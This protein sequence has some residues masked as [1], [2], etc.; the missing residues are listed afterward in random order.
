[1]KNQILSVGIDIGTTTTQVIFSQITVESTATSTIPEVKITDKEIIYKSEIYFTPLLSNCK[2]NLE[3]LKKIIKAEY[4]KAQV[5]KQEISVGAIIITGETARKENAREVLKAL[6]DFAGDFVVA[7]AG[8]DLESILAGYGAGAAEVSKKFTDYVVNFD[9]GG[10]TTNAAVF[11]DG[12]VVDSFA[13][14]IGG[15]LIKIDNQGVIQYISNKIDPL[16]RYLN[17]QLAVGGQ[18]NLTELKMLTDAFAA[19][20]LQM[21]GKQKLPEELERL[22]IL[23]THK[24]I[25]A[26]LFMFSGGVAEF[27]Y[28]DAEIRSL[29][30]VSRFGDIGP[31]LG[32][33]IRKM[34]AQYRHRLL[35]PKE[36]IRATVIGAGSYSVKISGSTIVFDNALL[37]L[38]NVPIIKLTTLENMQYVIEKKVRLYEDIPVAIAFSGPKSPSYIQ[39]KEMAKAI[40]HGLSENHHP[41]IVIV[42]HDFAK[43]LGQI[44]EHIICKQKPVICIDRIKVDNGDYVDIGK[45]I[46]DIVPVVV[47]TLIFKT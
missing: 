47:K 28:S 14:N 10:G 30:D 46:T 15:R 35:E 41:M 24:G 4:E 21:N 12:E 23:H 18:A 6:A 45:S 13:L 16:L 32:D 39:V 27:I 7:T 38:R 1:M 3:K 19:M 40:V 29:N 31:L 2:I 42:E 17:L 44:L 22:F 26:D 25:A 20:Y 8:P 43:A 33:S 34:F 11:L 5:Q 36:K 9:I 37:P